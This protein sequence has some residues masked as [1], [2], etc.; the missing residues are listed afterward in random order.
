MEDRWTRL[1]SLAVHGA[2]VQPGQT[3]MVSAEI[4]QEAVARAIAEDEAHERL[5][6]ELEH[7]LRLDEA[8]PEGAWEKRM[9]ALKSSAERLTERRFDAFELRG[10]G[11]ELTV[12]MLPTH[13]WWSADFVT[14]EGLRH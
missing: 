9:A 10:P 11:T 1:A 3:V 6:G 12:G 2:N 8:D 13:Q 5:W 14:A 4:G 7:V